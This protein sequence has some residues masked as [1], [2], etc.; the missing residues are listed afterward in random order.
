[1]V[2]SMIRMN[3][4]TVPYGKTA[5][6]IIAAAMD[7]FDYRLLRFP[8]RHEKINLALFLGGRAKLV[9]DHDVTLAF[10]T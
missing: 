9:V 7:E 2:G 3:D 1:M 4:N 10:D 5:N 8:G 6:E